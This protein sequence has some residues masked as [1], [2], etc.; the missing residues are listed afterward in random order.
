MKLILEQQYML[1]VLQNQYYACWYIGDFRSQSIS[2]YD[3]VPQTRNIPYL[4]SEEY[5]LVIGS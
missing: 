3:F 2:R 4:A 5:V 1:F